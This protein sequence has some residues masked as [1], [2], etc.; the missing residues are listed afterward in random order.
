MSASES[1]GDHRASP[2]RPHQA[3][4]AAAREDG[5]PAASEAVAAAHDAYPHQD[6]RTDP[7]WNIIRSVN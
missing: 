7:D 3:P 1:N 4:T 5:G 2:D 6:D